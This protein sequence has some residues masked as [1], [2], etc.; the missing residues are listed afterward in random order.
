M[1]ITQSLRRAVQMGAERIATR[2]GSRVKT[3]G[4]FEQ[5]VA[6][7]AGALQSL[8]VQSDDRVAILALNSDRY[9]ETYFA[10]PWT[11][12]VVVPINVRLAPPEIIYTLNDS[13]TKVLIIDDAFAAMLPAFEGQLDTV[14]HIIFAGDHE[15]PAG[16]LNYELLIEEA[17]PIEDEGRGG[18][19]IAGL[20]YTGGTTGRSKGVMLSHNNIISNAAN[21]V[22]SMGYTDSTSYLHAAPMFHLADGASTFAVT[23]VGGTHCFIP[24]FTPTDFLTSVSNFK[25]THGLLV[26]TMI[27][28][29]INEPTLSDYD[30]SS[31]SRLLYGASP[32]PEAVLL[33][34]MKTF[35][36]CRFLQGYGMTETSPLITFLSDEYHVT[37]GDKT[38]KLA[39][40]GRAGITVE[41][42]I[43]DENDNEVPRHTVGEVLTR[44]P[45]VMLGYWKMPELSETTLRRGWM[46][47]G[48]MA[49]MDDEGFIYI[50]DRNKDMIISGG[51]NVYS[52]EVETALYAHPAV[53]ECAVIG[54]PHEQW[55]EQVH[56]VVVLQADQKT[57][58]GDLISHCKSLIAGYKCPRSISF[59]EEPLPLSGAGKILKTELRKPFWKDKN[60]QV[61]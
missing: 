36:N 17:D 14:E 7:F 49:Y 8:S 3:W 47:T 30:L 19:E 56:A 54:I 58:E 39:S 28:M 48:D 33:Q 10:I 34:A 24:K 43:A 29:L 44:G 16:T 20:F 55:G 23:I 46:H 13:G 57:S 15:A 51:E 27:N 38:G 42:M 11:D 26:P 40:A 1:Y 12:A 5:R 50:V 25:V 6:S 41:V 4:E 37:T 2:C 22:A 21:V 45:H 9:L 35:P 53:K 52:T 18:Q 61:S 60:K 32:M 31:L 59:R